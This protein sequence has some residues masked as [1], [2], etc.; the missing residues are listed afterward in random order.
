VHRR[1]CIKVFCSSCFLQVSL[2]SSR[3]ISVLWWE[4]K[5]QRKFGVQRSQGH[6]KQ[7]PLE[8]SERY[9]VSIDLCVACHVM[10]TFAKNTFSQTTYATYSCIHIYA[11][12]YTF[13]RNGIHLARTYIL[14]ALISTSTCEDTAILPKNKLAP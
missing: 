5:Q 8:C 7:Q 13:G 12:I 9:P 10:A 4:S 14:S 3:T 2:S 6:S 1:T 11:R